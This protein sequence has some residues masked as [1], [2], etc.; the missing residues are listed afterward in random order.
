MKRKLCLDCRH[1]ERRADP[2]ASLPS[3]PRLRSHC[4]HHDVPAH[5]A[6]KRNGVCGVTAT[7]F[8]AKGE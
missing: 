7:D 4:T 6:R 3:M 8:E 2:G 5:V 1:Y